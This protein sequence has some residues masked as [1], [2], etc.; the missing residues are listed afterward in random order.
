M[1]NKKP[2][3]VTGAHRSGTTWLGR[4]IA[5]N[6]NIRY[7]HEPF[8]IGEKR[9]HPLKHWFEY[10]TFDDEPEKQK[11]IYT[12]IDELLDFN[13]PGIIKD[14]K[15][16]SGPRDILNFI[17]DSYNRINKRPLIKDPI[18]IMS[19]DWLV[20]K[21]DANAVILIR[22]PAAFVA[23][24]KVKNWEHTFDHYVKQDK[25]MTLLEPYAD[26]ILSFSKVKPDII[27]QGILLWNISYFR[28]LQYKADYPDW[29]Y[30][31]HEDLS[32]NPVEEIKKIYNELDL[33]FTKKIEDKITESSSAKVETRLKRDSKKNIHSWKKRLN[34]EEINRI[35]QG[36]EAVASEF[37]SDMD[38]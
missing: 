15:T 38:W 4:M 22:H 23:S 29:I 12:Y 10:V 32:L 33:N 35:K 21:F 14:L 25:L 18:A 7:I 6:K 5:L 3:I 30:V 9:I 8:N 36:T 26:K 16:I 27:D 13:M 17:K 1:N 20:E 19:T 2:I 37:Y 34:K 24:L 31:R 28:V 11:E